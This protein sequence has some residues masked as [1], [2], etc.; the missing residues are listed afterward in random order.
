MSALALLVWIVVLCL[1][2]AIVC[3][4]ISKL[5]IEPGTSMMVQAAILLILA[6]LILGLMFGGVEVPRLVVR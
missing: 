5:P 6:L 1:V 2:V 3:I 4:A